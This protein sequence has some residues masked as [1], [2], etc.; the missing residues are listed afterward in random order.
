[1]YEGHRVVAFVPAGRQRVMSILIDNLRRFTGIIDE[2]QIWLNTDPEQV[3]DEAWLRRLPQ[4]YPGWATLREIDAGEHTRPK[5]YATGRFYR[6]T[7]EAGTVYVRFDDDIVFIDDD[8]FERMLA[9]RLANR[10]PLL[11][12]GNIWNNAVVS[13]IH[14]Q[15]GSLDRENGVVGAPFCMDATGWASP[16]FGVHLHRVLLE[17]IAQGTT[18]ELFFDR[19]ELPDPTRFSISNF[20]FL[21]EDC[22]AWGGVTGNRDE[23]IFLTEEY[24]RISGRRNVIFGGGLVAHYSFFTQ[25]SLL[26]QTDILERYR[27]IARERL[28]RDYYRLLGEATA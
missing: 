24:P 10:E 28:S 13:W 2:L 27:Q 12:F 1:M 14:Q 5:Q 9:F 4:Q 6:Y 17:R 19:V 20:S 18:S 11:V 26:D 3:E 22:A 15:R 21:G 16:E 7:Q 8:Y 23:E 25:R